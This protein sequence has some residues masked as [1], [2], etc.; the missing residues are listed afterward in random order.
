[1]PRYV[2]AAQVKTRIL[3]AAML[4]SGIG[5]MLLTR[6]VLALSGSGQEIWLGA[7]VLLGT[8]KSRLVLD[9]VV[10]KNMARL[11]GLDGDRCIG[12][13]YSVKTWL[14]VAAMIVMGRL[15][16][17]SPLP[18]W[19]IGLIYATVGWALFWS[20]RRGWGA[21]R[22]YSQVPAAGHEVDES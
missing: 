16:R 14:L 6:G 22:Q 19:L 2:P 5:L 11:R 13:V 21:W 12:G 8:I 7:A 20:S 3:L 18:V 1:M 15:L 10:L 9:R 17:A 4:W